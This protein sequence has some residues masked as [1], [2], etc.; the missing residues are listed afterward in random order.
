MNDSRQDLDGLQRRERASGGVLD[1]CGT[2][3]SR[4]DRG[5]TR[6]THS[7]IVGRC[8]H[9]DWETNGC[10]IWEKNWSPYV[11]PGARGQ[12]PQSDL[13][14]DHSQDFQPFSVASRNLSDWVWQSFY[15]LQEKNLCESRWTVT[16]I[17]DHLEDSGASWIV[18]DPKRSMILKNG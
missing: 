1:I 17:L 7:G 12:K 6:C 8:T 2:S 9:W 18:L 13:S 10:S 14:S 5:G 3:A 15:V 11:S 4:G 16:T